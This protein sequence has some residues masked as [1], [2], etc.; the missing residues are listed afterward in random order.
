MVYCCIRAIS[1]SSKW[2]IVALLPFSCL[3]LSNMVNCSS[4]DG[5]VPLSPLS[6]SFYLLSLSSRALPVYC[7][8]GA[9]LAPPL[10]IFGLCC[11][12]APSLFLSLSPLSVCLSLSLAPRQLSVRLTTS[13]AVTDLEGEGCRRLSVVCGR[14]HCCYR[15]SFW[16]FK[17]S[18]DLTRQSRTIRLSPAIRQRSLY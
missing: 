16:R 9:C 11:I 18:R 4:C 1:L 13:I 8:I 6:D 3:S 10:S 14:C 12:R 15:R 5:I 2:I 7:C 17:L